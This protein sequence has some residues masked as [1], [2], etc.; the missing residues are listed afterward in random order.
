MEEKKNKDQQRIMMDEI[1]YI[2][3]PA[4]IRSMKRYAR[5]FVFIVVPL[6]FCMAVCLAILSKS[7]TKKYYVAGGTFMVGVRLSDSLSFDYN[8]SGI[9]WGRQSTMAH[10]NDVLTMLADSGYLTQFVKDSMGIKRNEELNGQIFVKAAYS[11]N[12]IDIYVVSESPEEAETIRDNLFSSLPD[13]VFPAVGFIEMDIESLYTREEASSRA[14][15]TS[16]KVWAAGGVILGII[17]YLGLVFLYTLRRR[18]VETPND[19]RKLTELSCIGRFPA[20]R[21]RSLFH[22]GSSTEEL[23]DYLVVTKEYQRVFDNFRSTIAEE[24]RQGQIRVIL[25]TGRSHKKG[26]TTIASEL[27]KDWL[28]MGK[29]V[30]LTSLT[31]MKDSASEEGPLTEE[32]VRSSLNKNLEEADIILIDGPSFDQSV[33]SLILADCADAMIMVIRE[34]QS[35]PDEIKEMFQSLEYANARPLG[36]VLNMCKNI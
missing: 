25:L 15:L 32:K 27:E 21:R 6:I 9:N 5:K 8:L 10:M 36:Y 31:I 26:Q 17:G 33:E 7:Y 11:T 18:D 20:L 34:G 22:K 16:P 29:K 4:F 19:L 30:I 14:F 23:N 1:D 12:L 28:K 35:Q 2:D 24:I 13:A 3:I